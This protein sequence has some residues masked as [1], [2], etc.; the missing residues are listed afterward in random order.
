MHAPLVL[1]GWVGVRSGDPV[2]NHTCWH[3]TTN[4]PTNTEHPHTIFL[5]S[6]AVVQRAHVTLNKNVAPGCDNYSN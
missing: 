5:A 4:P 6:L 1:K 2:H 3:L